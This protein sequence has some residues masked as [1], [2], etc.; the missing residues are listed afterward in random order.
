LTI[1]IKYNISI[2]GG[3]VQPPRS[4][5]EGFLGKHVLVT[6]YP[7]VGKTTLIRRVLAGA[8]GAS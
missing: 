7:G 5:K 2:L 6:G 4:S 3:I 8:M 1:F